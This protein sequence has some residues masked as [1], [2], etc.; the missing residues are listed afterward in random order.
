[1][2]HVL[3]AFV[4]SALLCSASFAAKPPPPPPSPS[5][6]PQVAYRLPD[7]K[8]TK[9]VVSAESGASQMT[10]YKSSTSFRF[11]LAPRAQQQIAIV[12]G[13]PRTLKLLNY[14]VNTS[15][16]YVPGA[17]NSLGNAGTSGAVDFSP[18][19]TK[20]A[21]SCCGNDSNQLIVHDIATGTKTVWA[22]GP[23]FW[24]IT[25]FRGGASIV[26]S[27]H[28]PLEV[29]EVTAPMAEPQLLYSTTPGGQ[30]DVDSARTNPNQLVISYND[31]QGSGRIGLWE[32]G[33][34]MVNPDL[35]SSAKS[36]QGTLNCDDKK[37][38]YMGVQNAS[39]SQAFYVRELNSGITTLVSKNSNILL[40]FW[41][42]C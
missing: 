5:S 37:L 39:G 19:G 35:A 3:C 26:Y 14:S 41:P 15:G 22:E 28:L 17:I 42:T 4:G 21:Y 29:R 10:L 25:W 2:R 11:D 13:S 6:S 16:V 34:G 7:G 38:A 33:T 1:M 32:D 27:T 23:Y 40:Q 36:W 8:G 24:D 18:D 30:L 12:D 31:A 9:L 20:I